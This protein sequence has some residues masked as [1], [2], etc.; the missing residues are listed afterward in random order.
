MMVSKDTLAK[1]D[2]VRGRYQQ[3]QVNT[4]AS[5]ESTNSVGFSDSE[6]DTSVSH[7]SLSQPSSN[8]NNAN[9]R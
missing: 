7:R 2:V 3:M 8:A 9:H 4:N 5:S 6:V 1:R